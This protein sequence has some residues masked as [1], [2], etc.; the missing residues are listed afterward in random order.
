EGDR[1]SRPCQTAGRVG[2]RT[3]GKQ[4][5]AGTVA[6]RARGVPETT[7]HAAGELSCRSV[8]ARSEDGGLV[9]GAGGCGAKGQAA[10][11][12]TGRGDPASG[13]GRTNQ[14]GST[15]P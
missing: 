6:A 2:S 15:D 12:N 1:S 5:G 13:R 3:G 7:A 11:G 8:Q 14:A 10:D 9:V 4:A